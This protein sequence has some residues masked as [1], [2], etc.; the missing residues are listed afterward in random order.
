MLVKDKH[1]YLKL[2]EVITCYYHKMSSEYWF[3]MIIKATEEEHSDSYATK[4]RV[5]TNDGRITLCRFFL[6]DQAREGKRQKIP[7][8]ATYKCLL[9]INGWS[10][11]ALC[12]RATGLIRR[13]AREGYDFYSPFGIDRLWI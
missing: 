5:L 12:Y 6:P 13:N 9:C 7:F 10:N 2:D 3:H 1:N 8:S 4:V 11:P